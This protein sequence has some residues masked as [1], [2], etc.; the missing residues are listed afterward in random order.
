MILLT[1]VETIP[2]LGCA[3]SVPEE[4]FFLCIGVNYPPLELPVHQQ[5][6]GVS[7]FVGDA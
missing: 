6:E 5:M 7:Q 2:F 4:G 3:Q 1:H